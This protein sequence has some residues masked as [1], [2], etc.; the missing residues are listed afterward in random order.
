MYSESEHTV[1]TKG[2]AIEGTEQTMDALC[3]HLTVSDQVGF[4][5]CVDGKDDITE[6]ITSQAFAFLERFWLL[7]AL[8]KPGQSVLDLGVYIGTFSPF[9][10]APA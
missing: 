6:A 7:V 4:D 3:Y 2:I 1:E 10:A 5:V 8:L 9:A